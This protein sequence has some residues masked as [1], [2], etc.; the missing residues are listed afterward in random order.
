MEQPSLTPT[1]SFVRDLADGQDVDA[2]FL[3]RSHSRRQKRKR[4]TVPEAPARDQTGDPEAVVWDGVDECSALC[5]AGAAV[6]VVG[7]YAV[8]ARYGAGLT[9]RALRAAAAEEYDP[10]DLVED[11]RSPTSRWRP[12]SSR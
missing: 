12:I 9:V 1:K 4:R 6:Q 10:A 7:R 8:D 5:P 2:V 11:R 3:V